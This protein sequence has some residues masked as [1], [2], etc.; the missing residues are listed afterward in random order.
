MGKINWLFNIFV[1]RNPHLSLFPLNFLACNL[2][3]AFKITFGKS[4]VS[5]VAEGKG[6]TAMY[7]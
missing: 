4:R 2:K 7:A 6:A 1:V 5:E 3:T